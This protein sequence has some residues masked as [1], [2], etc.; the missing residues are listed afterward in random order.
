MLIYMR[1]GMNW[2][3]MRPLYPVQ[4]LEVAWKILR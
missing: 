1:V 3:V 4:S 2:G